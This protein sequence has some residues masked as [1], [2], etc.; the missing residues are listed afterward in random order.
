MNKGFE[1]TIETPFEVVKIKS[2]SM[3][4]KKHDEKADVI[5]DA[6]AYVTPSSKYFSNILCDNSDNQMFYAEQYGGAGIGS[7]GGGVRAGNVGDYQV[8]GIGV[9]HLVG[10]NAD[11][12]HSTGIYSV[13]EAITETINS[14]IY[15]KILPIGVVNMKAIIHIGECSYFEQ[16]PL[17]LGVREKA[18]RPAHFMRAACFEPFENNKPFVIDDVERVR[19]MNKA[20]YESFPSQKEFTQFLELF[21]SNLANQFAFGRIHQI[22]HG[23]LS[24]SNLSIDGK[25][26]DLTNMSFIPSAINYCA[27]KDTIP[28]YSEP[29][30]LGVFIE[31][32][33]HG[34]SKYNYINLDSEPFIN[35]FHNQFDIYLLFYIPEK[36]GLSSN[37]MNAKEYEEA[38]SSL[39]ELYNQ[40]CETKKKPVVGFPLFESF[41]ED[42]TVLLIL[43]VYKEAVTQPFLYKNNASSP[44]RQLISVRA[45]NEKITE[46]LSIAL[47]F[48]TA[49]KK[50]LFTPSLYLGEIRNISESYFENNFNNVQS[51]IDK[52]EQAVGWIFDKDNQ[53][54]NECAIF[55]S[56]TLKISISRNQYIYFIEYKNKKLYFDSIDKVILFI[57]NLSDAAFI[58]LARNYKGQVIYLFTHLLEIE[59]LA[60]NR[61]REETDG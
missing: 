24:P 32:W 46:K 36:F 54:I 22:A 11:V 1:T 61:F 40:V 50:Q 4:W 30:E 14:I 33:L 10:A 19:N 35:Y 16:L 28:F 55:V 3:V 42:E 18:L 25:W 51:F 59:T 29:F 44:L 37:M 45:K 15:N 48:I 57:D 8:K 39:F 17:A 7:N 49:M 52:Y 31:E 60:S 6:C 38:K 21:L 23:A 53:S 47:S 26:L 5:L 20:F 34:F 12:A 41:I 13:V 56:D 43:S 9:N 58:A 27:S 2:C